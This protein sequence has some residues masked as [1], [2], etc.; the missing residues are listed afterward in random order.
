MLVGITLEE[1][2]SLICQEA[3][4]CEQAAE[5]SVEEAGGAGRSRAA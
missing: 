1:A 2:V 4:K 3:K 5:I